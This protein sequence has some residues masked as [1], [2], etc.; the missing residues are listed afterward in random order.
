MKIQLINVTY[1][2][3]QTNSP[4]DVTAR[5]IADEVGCTN[6]AIYYHFENIDH[7]LLIASM[8]FFDDY[9]AKLKEVMLD[10][11]ISPFDLHMRAWRM[12]G[13]IAFS[14]VEVYESIFWG[15]Y[16]KR[17]S[18]ALLEYYQLFPASR[19]DTD[20]PY[21]V[22]FFIDSIEERTYI[23][24]KI[25]AAAGQMPP[26]NLRMFANVQCSMFHGMLLEYAD[27][28]WDPEKAKEGLEKTMRMLEFLNAL[29]TVK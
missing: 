4:N 8:R 18:K 22:V 3:L 17:A 28:Y 11:S 15:K 29:Y 10:T 1:R 6:P 16:R 9:L 14:H 24:L 25:A 21:S 20:S 2:L 7:L 26:E 13:E 27:C 19:P 23:M 12:F 5:M